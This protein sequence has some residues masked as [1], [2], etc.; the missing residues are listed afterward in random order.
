MYNFERLNSLLKKIDK[1]NVF[2]VSSG[3]ISLREHL[4]LGLCDRHCYFCSL[5]ETLKPPVGELELG[6]K[7][8]VLKAIV[9]NSNDLRTMDFS[10]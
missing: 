6:E 8:P 9:D 3:E 10:I 7:F 1:I 4:K 2:L 5:R